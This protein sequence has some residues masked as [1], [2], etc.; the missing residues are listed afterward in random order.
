MKGEERAFRDALGMFTTGITV[1]TTMDPDGMPIGMTANSF[2]SL[3]LEPPL[4]IWNVGDHS[5]CHDTFIAAEHFCVH[6]L[7]AGQ[8]A[9]SIQ[10]ATT[11]GDKFAGLQWR[12]GECGSPVLSDY[13]ACFECV[14]EADH[15]GGDHRIIVGRVINYDDRG[16]LLP[17]LYHRGQYQVLAKT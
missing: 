8:K 11:S 17:L 12:R 7:H 10:F 16:D 5:Y 13:A 15:P 14:K 1:V 2:A 3:S 4:V 9:L 6:I